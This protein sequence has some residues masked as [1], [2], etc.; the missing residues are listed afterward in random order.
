MRG[1]VNGMVIPRKWQVQ[2]NEIRPASSCLRPIP[3]CWSA[4]IDHRETVL[5]KCSRSLLIQ[6][7]PPRQLQR[8][9]HPV[10]GATVS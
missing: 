5:G 1:D 3:D 9:H 7:Q 6:R 4:A 2:V 10:R 8:A